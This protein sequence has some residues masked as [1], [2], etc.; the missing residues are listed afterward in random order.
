M[1]RGVIFDLDGVLI[2]AKEWHYEALNKAL[3]LFGYKIS[4]YE[5]LVVYDGLPTRRKLEMLTIERGLPKSLHDFI[6]TMKQQ[7]TMEFIFT[8]CRPVFHHELALTK[9]KKEGYKLALCSNSIAKSVELMLKM[10]NLEKFFDI[11]LSNEDV[12]EPKPH[13]EIYSKAIRLLQL[14]PNDCLVLEDNDH[15]IKAA[16]QSG[17][18]VLVVNDINDTNYQNIKRAVKKYEKRP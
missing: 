6:N 16:K 12:S 10:S 3:G 14:K 9:L 18:H 17:A 2:D 11:I 1:I 8:K 7:F 15:G 5:H 13:P 4:R